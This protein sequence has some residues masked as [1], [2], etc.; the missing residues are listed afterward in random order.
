M[1]SSKSDIIPNL[2]YMKTKTFILLAVC[3]LIA[4]TMVKAQAYIPF[5]KDGKMWTE[6]WYGDAPYIHWVDTYTMVEDTF[7]NGKLYKKV[8]TNPN[9]SFYTYDDTTNKK[10][11]VYDFFYSKD[12]V[13][14]DFSLQVG[15]TLWL[16]CTYFILINKSME[17][18]AG[19]NRNKLEFCWDIG[20]PAILTWYEGIGSTRGVFQPFCIMGSSSNLL[21]YYENNMLLY[22]DTTISDSCFTL[23]NINELLPENLFNSYFYSPVLYVK[24]NKPVSYT[25]SIYDIFGRK[26]KEVT[27]VDN[28]E[29]DLSGLHNGLYIY[30]IESKDIHYSSKLILNQ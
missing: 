29:I 24:P 21:C 16:G 26:T 15:D 23:T 6:A 2:Y 10:I 25:L 28:L 12:S 13:W 30:R 7:F 1:F 4:N 8:Y 27:A 20:N 14:Y 9:Q 11:Y 19:K 22:H 17:Y 3:Y 18:F 5:T